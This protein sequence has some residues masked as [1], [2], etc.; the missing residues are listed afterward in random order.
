MNISLNTIERESKKESIIHNI[1]GRIK[2][3]F[4]LI[5][6]FYA[7]YT[8][9]I[10]LLILLEVYLILLIIISTINLKY[11]IKRILIL[12]PFG[13][14]IAVFQPFI[15]PGDILYSLPLGINITEQGLIFG[16]LLMS[17]LIVCLTCIILLSSTTTI[18]D[19]VNS[20]R[21]LGFPK[22][23]A[24]I[25]SLAIRYIFLFFEELDRI[26]NAQKSR[27]FDIWNK[28]TDYLWRVKQV[29]YTIAM[30]FLN[31]F[32]R[33][34]RVY[35]SMASRCYAGEINM[36]KSKTKIKNNEYIIIILT[37]FLI[38]SL[39]YIKSLGILS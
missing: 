6:I 29:G 35:F 4:T 39:E 7:V 20:F 8:T 14:F 16:I 27:C 11:V 2:L 26:R 38:F 33:G 21:R 34:E 30:I 15:K 25:M 37:I 13:G 22:D 32:E 17:R 3:I 36:Y 19:I 5:L 18:Q 12:L 24:M 28:K 31:G 23:L 10:K 9:E 1:D